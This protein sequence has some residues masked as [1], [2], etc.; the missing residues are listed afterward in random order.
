MITEM[1]LFTNSCCYSLQSY[2]I[3]N[4]KMNFKRITLLRFISFVL[5]LH[6]AHMDFSVAIAI[7]F[8]EHRKPLNGAGNMNRS[9]RH[10]RKIN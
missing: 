3:N 9:Y 2:Q 6:S 8:M 1:Q 5:C 7:V 4:N 10:T